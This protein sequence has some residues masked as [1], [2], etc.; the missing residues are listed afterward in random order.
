MARFDDEIDF[1]VLDATSKVA[2]G[3]VD[4]SHR[5]SR[6]WRHQYNRVRAWST[7]N[8]TMA[9]DLSVLALAAAVELLSAWSNRRR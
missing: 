2:F 3:A 8:P 7:V 9:R 5:F 1:R 4:L 6:E